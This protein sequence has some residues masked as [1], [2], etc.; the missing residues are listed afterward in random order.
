VGPRGKNAFVRSEHGALVEGWVCLIG[1]L[2]LVFAVV[3]DV[4]I[5]ELHFAVVG[6][7][8]GR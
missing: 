4:V 2:I 6:A 7:Q 5:G 8:L 1:V 3:D